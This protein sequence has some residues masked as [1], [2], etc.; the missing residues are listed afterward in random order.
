VP[1]PKYDLIRNVPL[2]A[3]LNRREVAT[4]AKL[5]EEV[6]VPAGRAIIRQ[7]R[8]GSEF[9]IILDGRVRI[10]RDGNVLS[11]LGPGDF[12]GEIALVD[13]RPRT[14]SAITEEPSRL[15]VLTSQ[16]FNSM[17][18]LHPAVESKVLRALA[19]RVRK[20]DPETV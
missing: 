15:F 18:R 2:F 5:L 4:L 12:L 7:G 11:E 14:A 6:D 9:F 1:N 13:G 8:R 19:Q 20:L 3:E 10:E 16:S 17:L